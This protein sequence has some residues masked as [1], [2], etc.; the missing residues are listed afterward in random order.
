MRGH[1]AVRPSLLLSCL[2][3]ASLAGSSSADASGFDAH[4][5]WTAVGDQ[6]GALFGSAVARA[7]DVNGDGFPDVIVGAPKYDGA[8]GVDCGKAFVYYGSAAGFPS[9]PSWTAEGEL[10]TSEFGTSVASAGDVNGDG[11]DDVVVGAPYYRTD[12]TSYPWEG[13]GR[14][15][16]Y[17]GSAQGLSPTAAFAAEGTW[18]N[19]GRDGGIGRLLASGDF[20]GDGFSDVVGVQHAEYDGAVW[21][22]YG[23]PSGLSPANSW[24]TLDSFY[25]IDFGNSVAVA[26]VNGDGSDDLIVTRVESYGISPHGFVFLGS[27]TGLATPATPDFDLEDSASAAGVGDVDRDGYDDLLVLA[28]SEGSNWTLYLELYRGAPSGAIKADHLGAT[29][30]YGGAVAGVSALGDVN[31]DGFPDSIATTPDWGSGSLFYF[32]LGSASGYDALS[33]GMGGLAAGEVIVAA[34]DADRDGFDDILSGDSASERVDL[35]R[36]G[37]DWSFEAGADLSVQVVVD[38]LPY[39]N[40]S[41]GVLITNSGPDTARLKVVGPIPPTIEGVWLDCGSPGDTHAASTCP[42]PSPKSLDDVITIGP[43]GSVQYWLFGGVL[44]E[45]VVATA[46]LILPRWVV[47]PDLSNNRATALSGSGAQLLFADGFESGDL[48]AWD[49]HTS[50]LAV[51][52]S[53]LEGDHALRVAAPVLGRALVRD[54]TPESESDYHA[55]FLLDPG[56]SGRCFVLDSGR[57]GRFPA[58]GRHYAAILFSAHAQGP[59]H[60]FFDVLLERKECGLS[61]RL[62]AALDDGTVR[63]TAGVPLSDARHLIEVGWRRSSGPASSDGQLLLRL[64]GVD[65]AGWLGLNN[66][67]GGGVDYVDLGLETASRPLPG[68]RRGTVLLDAFESWRPESQPASLARSRSTS[69]GAAWPPRLTR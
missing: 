40:L 61:L 33:S 31:G 58:R 66:G 42:I 18:N 56:G 23:S 27:T 9:V 35:Y 59:A 47:D 44:S 25:T 12:T 21:V 15:Y 54:D 63:E 5:V 26:D 50:G 13:P 37:T 41:L 57:P 7:G 20:N 22:Y 29:P 1:A 16:V 60:S 53:R 2:C 3:L 51:V 68:A 69:S 6:P 39:P 19:L 8:A 67:A 65:A 48:S 10:E 4:R 45:P 64:D 14:I 55:R 11:F 46:L 62:R 43:G 38:Q 34:G 36:G 32:F 17:L 28:A 24:S 52:P 49:S 30:G